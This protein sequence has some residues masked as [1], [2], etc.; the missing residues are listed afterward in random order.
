MKKFLLLFV[1]MLFVSAMFATNI[2]KEAG[3]LPEIV[4]EQPSN[5]LF[6][7]AD[8]EVSGI[9]TGDRESEII[10]GPHFTVV[11]YNYASPTVTRYNF[12]AAGGMA[13]WQQLHA[14]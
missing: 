13:A 8:F 4:I 9:L 11:N 10:K 7:A 12:K 3:V 2:E 5:D 6:F 14:H 1:S